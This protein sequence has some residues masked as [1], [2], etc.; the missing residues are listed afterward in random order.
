V[1]VTAVVTLIAVGG[2]VG[3]LWNSFITAWPS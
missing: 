1:M 2:A 3:T